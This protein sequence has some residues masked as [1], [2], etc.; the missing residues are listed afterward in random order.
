MWTRA[1]MMENYNYWG[2]PRVIEGLINHDTFFVKNSNTEINM[3]WVRETWDDW[4]HDEELVEGEDDWTLQQ[5]QE[6]R[7]KT[8]KQWLEN[9]GS[10]ATV[11]CESRFEICNTCQGRGKHVNPSIDCN[12][13]TASEWAD[14]DEEDQERY[15][16]GGYDVACS[17]CKGERVIQVLEYD[18]KNL[19]YNWCCERLSEYYEG[20]YQS[21]QEYAW[22]K[23]MGC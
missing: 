10:Q 9:L 13:I 6:A 12:G 5:W 15:W 8:Y 3:E 11:S 21:A 1:Q 4:S 2:D 18:T 7:E 16:T 19:L 22:E 23:R 14:W 17:Q 20:Q